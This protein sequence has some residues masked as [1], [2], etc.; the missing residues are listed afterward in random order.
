MRDEWLLAVQGAEHTQR[1]R[2][3]P[4]LVCQM[5]QELIDVPA[6]ELGRMLLAMENDEATNPVE[7][8]LLR[9]PRVAAITHVSAQLVEQADRG[10][11]HAGSNVVHWSL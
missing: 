9:L 8:G 10:H 6:G 5:A 2:G 7:V 1:G 4:A 3:T 11:R